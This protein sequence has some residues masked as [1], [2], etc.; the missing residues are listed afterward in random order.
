MFKGE[1]KKKSKSACSFVYFIVFKMK[2]T[3]VSWRVKISGNFN[4]NTNTSDSAAAT[5]I[6]LKLLLLLL[7]IG[8]VELN[9][10]PNHDVNIPHEKPAW[11]ETVMTANAEK[12]AEKTA[13]KILETLQPRLV[14]IETAV[15]TNSTNINTLQLQVNGLITYAEQNQTNIPSAELEHLR[16]EVVRLKKI[17]NF[18]IMGVEGAD[19]QLDKK[20]VK[21]ILDFLIP[22]SNV[23]P[24]YIERVGRVKP[25]VTNVRPIRVALHEHAPKSLIFANRSSLVNNSKYKNVRIRNDLT[26][27]QIRSN[28]ERRSEQTITDSASM[29]GTQASGS[30]PNPSQRAPKRAYSAMDDAV[31]T[32]NNYKKGRPRRNTPT[33]YAKQGHGLQKINV[34]TT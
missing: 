1:K 11:L 17:N 15:T 24:K 30:N 29:H 32:Q 26:R 12:T 23:V 7:I 18:I 10:G 19:E 21:D 27:Q 8:C 9:P 14:Q 6:S 31:T 2:L 20:Y 33:Q 5:C 16:E 3:D 13:E 34:K 25:D 28:N 22:N 4:K